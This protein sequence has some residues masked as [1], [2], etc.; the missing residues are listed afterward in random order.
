MPLG[1]DVKEEA[2]EIKENLSQSRD[3]F[4]HSGKYLITEIMWDLTLKQCKTNL[5]VIKDSYHNELEMYEA[6]VDILREVST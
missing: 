3:S 6:D 5:K 4:L 2:T 1:Y